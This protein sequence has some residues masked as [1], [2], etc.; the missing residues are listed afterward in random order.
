MEYVEI[1]EN[2]QTIRKFKGADTHEEAVKHVLSYNKI[3]VLS[4]ESITDHKGSI[5]QFIEDLGIK[6]FI[7]IGAF[8][9]EGKD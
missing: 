7:K 9:K 6:D 4:V 8:N 2:S 5:D 1:N 3:R